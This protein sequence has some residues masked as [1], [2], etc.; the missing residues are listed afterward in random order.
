MFFLDLILNLTG[1]VLWLKWRDQPAELTGPKISL[2]G[3]LRK[4]DNAQARFWFLLGLILLLVL[5]PL[6]YW[7]LGSALNW[8][9]RLLLGVISMPFRSDYFGRM[10]L[11]SFLNFGVVLGIFY[12]FLLFLSALNNDKTDDPVQQAIRTQLGKLTLLPRIVK[13]LLPGLVL[14]AV[15]CSLHKPLVSLGLL[16][17]AKSFLHLLEQ[18]VVTGMAIYLAGK[19]LVAGILLLHLLN[20]YIY[21]G[22]WPFWNFIDHSAK[23]LLKCVAWIPLRFG[24]VDFAPPF[25]IAL[26]F[27]LA[28]YADKGLSALYLR[29]PL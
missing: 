5:R 20:S 19:Y 18:G 13:V 1:L 23:P 17:A 29:L 4:T 27:V 21:F 22:P 25:A 12:S 10:F 16:P 9:P 8:T 26:V 24:K 6:P 3:T 2:L 7:I 15:W 11:F 14:L 28:K